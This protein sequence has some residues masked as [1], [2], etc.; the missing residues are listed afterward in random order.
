[1]KGAKDVKKQLFFRTISWEELL[2]RR[3]RPPYIPTIVSNVMPRQETKIVSSIC[4][5]CRM[6]SKMCQILTRNVQG[7]YLN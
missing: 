2:M 6:V 4:I 3:V 5:F 7:R 1:M